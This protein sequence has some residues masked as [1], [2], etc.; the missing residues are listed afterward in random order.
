MFLPVIVTF[1]YESL[2][3]VVL[4]IA[5]QH[6]LKLTRITAITFTSLMYF[7]P[8]FAVYYPD[9]R[10]IIPG[11]LTIFVGIFV[12]PIIGLLGLFFVP[13]RLKMPLLIASV[14]LIGAP[15]YVLVQMR[16]TR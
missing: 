15:I 8:W 12:L 13:K 9:V 7:G 11:L 5:L 10:A 1:A 16:V 4:L 3:M 6:S 14:L 2:G